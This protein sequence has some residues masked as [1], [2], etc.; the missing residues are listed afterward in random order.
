M[1]APISRRHFTPLGT[2]LVLG[3]ATAAASAEDK[4]AAVAIP[5]PV[6][7]TFERDYPAPEFKPS[8]KKPQINRLLVQD[9][10]RSSPSR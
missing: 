5:R 7:T 2:G 9:F 1:A 3:S 4:T 10:G 8:W 6:E